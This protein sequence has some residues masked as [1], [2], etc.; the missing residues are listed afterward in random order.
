MSATER[1]EA[2]QI[3][4][5]VYADHGD[6]EALKRLGWK[7]SKARKGS[8]AMRLGLSNSA[9]IVV[10]PGAGPATIS[11]TGFGAPQVSGAITFELSSYYAPEFWRMDR[12][13]R[14]HEQQ[15][16]VARR[17]TV[18]LGPVQAFEQ[19]QGNL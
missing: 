9:G 11:A 14:W 15:L 3:G 5:Q 8:V 13:V 16:D 4:R 18:E 12:Y 7:F 10:F 6:A 1:E 17:G 2:L 19:P